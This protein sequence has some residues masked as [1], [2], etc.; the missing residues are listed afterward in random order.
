MKTLIGKVAVITGASSGIGLAIAKQLAASGCRVALIA[1][2]ANNLQKA[3]D[4]VKQSTGGRAY[5]FECDLRNRDL[6]I[7]TMS[8]IK[9]TLGS[10]D[11]LVNNAGLGCFLPIHFLSGDQL[12][13]PLDVPVFST[14][15]ASHCVV[16]D[17]I[18]KK[19]GS[20]I[21]IITP[22]SYFP[23]PYMCHYTA[24]RWAL[25]GLSQSLEQELE[26][27]DIQ[28]ATI[29]PGRVNTDYLQNND[30][31]IN[32]WPRISKVFSIS[33][34]G[35]VA[36]KVVSAITKNKR[37]IIFPPLLWFFVKSYRMFPRTVL[38]GL[39]KLHLFQPS[40]PLDTYSEG[41]AK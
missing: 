30:A 34:P 25:L 11:I 38:W 37:E 40:M 28:V 7:A 20:I 15:V 27:H 41:V 4:D 21:N 17:M 31:D 9:A 35:F 14:L 2:N 13:Q 10:V 19:S 12:A 29:C 26:R 6:L 1:R 18:A 23:L 22:A 39:K 3:V 5:S 33:Q 36:K 16:D 32:W 8:Q 24:S